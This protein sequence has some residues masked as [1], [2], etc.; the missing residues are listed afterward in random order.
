MVPNLHVIGSLYNIIYS[1]I[2]IYILYTSV[3]TNYCKSVSGKTHAH[4]LFLQSRSKRVLHHHS[5]D[6]N[7]GQSTSPMVDLQVGITHGVYH[8]IRKP[9][10]KTI[11]PA[12]NPFESSRSCTN[13]P[14]EVGLELDSCE[15]AIICDELCLFMSAI[16]SDA[17]GVSQATVVALGGLLA[18]ELLAS[19]FQG[20]GSRHFGKITVQQLNNERDGILVI[21]Y[22]FNASR[23]L[24]QSIIFD[25]LNS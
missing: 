25:S 5:H 4:V 3:H 13:C 12:L 22:L 15:I 24:Q 9:C 18:L 23:C 20:F 11:N 2:Y 7:H 19:R 10:K 16:P 21:M 17:A 6:G 14:V 1:S 8:N